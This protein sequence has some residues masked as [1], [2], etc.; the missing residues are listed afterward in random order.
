M[1]GTGLHPN[2]EP[3]PVVNQM[4]LH[5]PATKPVIDTGSW[6]GVSMNTKPLVVMGSP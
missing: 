5:P 4:M 3:R 2:T 6:P 1:E